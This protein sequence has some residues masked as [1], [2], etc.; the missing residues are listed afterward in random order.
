MCS[1]SFRRAPP[2]TRGHALPCGVSPHALLACTRCRLPVL[3]GHLPLAIVVAEL[4]VAVLVMPHRMQ[5]RGGVGAAISELVVELRG[6]LAENIMAEVLGHEVCS[7]L[8]PG[9]LSKLDD[10]S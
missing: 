4:L 6:M 10:T 5:L 1:R 3:R 8:C 7:M 2:L 9:D